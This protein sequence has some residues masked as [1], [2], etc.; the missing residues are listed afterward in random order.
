MSENVGIPYSEKEVLN[1]GQRPENS[2]CLGPFF[3]E[4]IGGEGVKQGENDDEC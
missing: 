3:I 2:H 1:F 4:M